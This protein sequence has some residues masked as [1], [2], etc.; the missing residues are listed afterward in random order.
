MK[1]DK[2]AE[3]YATIGKTNNGRSFSLN[4]VK[5]FHQTPDENLQNYQ[6]EVGD[7]IKTGHSPR[8]LAKIAREMGLV[9][10]DDPTPKSRYFMRGTRQK[11][12]QILDPVLDWNGDVVETLV[13]EP[14][15]AQEAAK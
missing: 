4:R 14:Y 1:T 12:G 10:L 8:M 6:I 11:N 5:K 15:V 9:L 13:R 2:K 3:E 7:R